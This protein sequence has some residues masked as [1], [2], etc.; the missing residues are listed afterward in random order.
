[1]QDSIFKILFLKI[2]F[3]PHGIAMPK[4]LYFT[5]VFF[6]LSFLSFSFFVLFLRRVISEVTERISTKLEHVLTYDC[7]LKNLVL[8]FRGIYFPLAGG[9]KRFLGPT[10]N[11]YRTY[12]CNGT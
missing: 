5:A 6:F 9:Q 8:T 4:G 7:C 11:F 3:S 1:M 12:L 10:L 2:V